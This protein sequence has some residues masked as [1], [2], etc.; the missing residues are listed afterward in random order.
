MNHRKEN[1]MAWKEDN[2]NTE[3]LLL[4]MRKLLTGAQEPWG[5]FSANDRE[6]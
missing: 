4:P 6:P 5:S 1:F 3:N 2:T